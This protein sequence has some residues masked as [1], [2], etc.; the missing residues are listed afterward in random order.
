MVNILMIVMWTA[1]ITI[2]G[3]GAG[4][5]FWY[6]TRPKTESWNAKVYQLADG[7]RQS[8]NGKIK[9]QDLRAYAVDVLIKIEKKEGTFYK[10]KKLNMT[11]PA[12]EG[13]VVEHWSPDN[14]Q[15][16]VLYSKSGCT[17]LRKGYDIESGEMVFD[18]LAH[19]RINLI[20]G[21]MST[22]KDRLRKSKDVLEAI[23]PW[24]V[25]GIT[26]LSLVAIAYIMITGF[27]TISDNLKDANVAIASGRNTII[28]EPHDLGRTDDSVNPDFL[29]EGI[30]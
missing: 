13:D 20:K 28:P 19:S 15:V 23:S 8:K 17:L 24:V 18:P 30:S 26:M 3:G 2:V 27:I 14:R 21:E 4:Y 11:T 1:I 25:A 7:I 29:P 10:L 6:K 22:R 9:I 12:V 5:F 16:A